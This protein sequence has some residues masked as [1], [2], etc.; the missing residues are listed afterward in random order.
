[1]HREWAKNSN[2]AAAIRAFCVRALRFAFFA[3]PCFF[4][5]FFSFLRALSL[6]RAA[7]LLC[8]CAPTEKSF[9]NSA[10]HLRNQMRKLTA[11]LSFFVFLLLVFFWKFLRVLSARSSEKSKMYIN[12]YPWTKNPWVT[13]YKKQ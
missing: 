12:V 13:S 9:K 10:I 3:A 5:R 1:M 8:L 2:R 6:S 11:S 7:S 4:S